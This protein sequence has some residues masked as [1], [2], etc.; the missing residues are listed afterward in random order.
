MFLTNLN[1]LNVLLHEVGIAIEFATMLKPS[2]PG[3]NAGNGVGTSRPSLKV[4]L[5]NNQKISMVLLLLF[6][7]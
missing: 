5:E 4:E 6:C 2:S 7:K 1:V 3:K